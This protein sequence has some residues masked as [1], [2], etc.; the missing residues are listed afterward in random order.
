MSSNFFEARNECLVAL[1]KQ[2]ELLAEHEEALEA[3]T[4]SFEALGKDTSDDTGRILHEEI[5]R[6]TAEVASIKRNIRTIEMMLRQ[7]YSLAPA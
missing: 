7:K 6:R 1:E 3:F 4:C 2:R 5:V